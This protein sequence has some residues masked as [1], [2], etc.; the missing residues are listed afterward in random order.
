MSR[1]R[2]GAVVTAAAAAVLAVVAVP[3][4]EPVDTPVRAVAQLAPADTHRGGGSCI[5]WSW[6]DG[7]VSTT[8]YFNNHCASA[9]WLEVGRNH[10]YWPKCIKV[11]GNTKGNKRIWDS[12]PTYV[13][14]KAHCTQQRG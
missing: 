8:I 10:Q 9:R 13:H 7:N 1:S 14:E 4:A 6:A 12:T 3:A 5:N 11:N 2:I